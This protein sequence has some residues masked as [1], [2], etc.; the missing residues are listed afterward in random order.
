MLDYVLKRDKAK[1]EIY[2]F[3]TNR[4]PLYHWKGS[5]SRFF[6]MSGSER[7]GSFSRVINFSRE[8]P[9]RHFDDKL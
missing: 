1:N 7:G 9:S 8:I 2:V 3:N 5:G 4:F 6:S